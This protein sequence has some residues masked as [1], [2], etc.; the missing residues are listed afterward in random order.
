MCV[1]HVALFFIT[2][3]FV[4]LRDGLELCLGLGADFLGDFV[5]VMLKR[6]LR[7]VSVPMRMSQTGVSAVVLTNLAVSLLDVVGAS[8]VVDAEEG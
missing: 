6:E 4:C 1:V 5:G 3:N 7:G 8:G 2:E